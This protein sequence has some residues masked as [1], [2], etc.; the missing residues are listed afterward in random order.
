MFQLIKDY[1]EQELYRHSFNRLTKMVY[2][3]DFEAWYQLGGWNERYIPYSFIKDDQVIANASVN[4]MEIIINGRTLKAIQIGT[5]MTDPEYRGMGLSRRLIETI[6]QD[7]E[8]RV[9]FI[10]LFANDTVLDF[11]PKFGFNKVLESNFLI[12]YQNNSLVEHRLRKLDLSDPNDLD[13]FNHYARDRYPISERCGVINA[14]HLHLF[15]GLN[16]FGKN[17]Y[18]IEDLKA[19]VI[20]QE[21]DQ[22]LD[23]Y[24]VMSLD[25]IGLETVLPYIVSKLETTVRCHF[26]PDLQ[27]LKASQSTLTDHTL[28]IRPM[29]EINH[30][31][32]PNI[33]HA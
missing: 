17:I 14:E 25:K 26:T 11:Y 23:L 21:N 18:Y 3:I 8:H 32:F 20:Y 1:K 9:D 28:F 15:Y 13:L 12:S 16:V 22:I 31:Q 10:Y 19:I 30:F 24:D 5:V 7:Y 27:L 2:G 6:I 4:K 29:I 33:S